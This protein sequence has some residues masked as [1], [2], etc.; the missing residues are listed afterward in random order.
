MSGSLILASLWAL[1]ATGV[2]LMP[3]RVQIAPGL[4][5]LLAA[6]GVVGWIAV[7]HGTWVAA[8]GLVGVLSMFRKPLWALMRR[9][10]RK[11]GTR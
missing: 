6:P 7:Q 3:Y 1:A 2:A 10:G 9:V 11:E 5:L 4:M 8:L